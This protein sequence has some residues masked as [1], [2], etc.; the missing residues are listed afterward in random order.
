MGF[1][2]KATYE[3]DGEGSR[4][5]KATVGYTDRARCDWCGDELHGYTSECSVCSVL[6]CP[7]HS[8]VDG[9]CPEHTGSGEQ[10][11]RED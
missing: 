3:G 7:I 4:E 10:H 5:I 9:R 8:C 11:A 6:L 1:Q 2:K